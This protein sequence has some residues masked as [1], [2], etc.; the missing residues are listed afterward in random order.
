LGDSQVVS[1]LAFSA[2]GKTLVVLSP[3]RGDWRKGTFSLWDV[4]T[5]KERRRHPFEID[6]HYQG[7]LSPDGQHFAVPT[8]D[9][10]SIR[11][12]DPATGQELRR[13][14]GEAHRPGVV[15]FSADGRVLT[16]SSGDGKARVWDTATGKLRHQFPALRSANIDHVSL[17]RDGALLALAGRD[18]SALHVWDL[19]RGQ[20]RPAFAGHRGSGLT[21]AFTR[22][23]KAV[24]TVS[25]D[26]DASGPVSEWADWSFRLW[27]A[28]SG[29][30]R[31]AT[32]AEPGGGGRLVFVAP[33]ARLLAAV[34]HDGTVRLWD[35]AAGQE[36]RRWKGPTRERTII[37]GTQV[38][39]WA[40]AGIE[41]AGFSPDGKT[42]LAAHGT[43]VSRWDTAT[44]KEL[45]PLQK[46]GSPNFTRC[47]PSPDGRTV[48]LTD[49]GRGGSRLLLLDAASGRLLRVIPARRGVVHLCAFSPDGRT[50]AL[51]DGLAVVLFEAASGQ[52]RGRLAEGAGG[53]SA[54][55][56]SPDGRF[57][58]TAGDRLRLWDL[59]AGRPAG[60]LDGPGFRVTSLAFS[61]DG[62]RLAVG[63]W[64][65]AAL[66]Y[67]VAE[68]HGGER[69]GR[70]KL[71]A[72]VL[73]G[74]WG[75]LA[76]PSGERAYRA[77]QRL[78]AAPEGVP[79][80]RGRLKAPPGPEARRLARLV[81]DLDDDDFAVREQATRELERLGARAEPALRKA[82]E[83]QPS[84]EVRA[85]VGGLLEKLKGGPPL[86]SAELVAQRALEALELA[87]TAEA[88]QALKE[89]TGG[90]PDGAIAEAAKAALERLAARAG[91]A[92]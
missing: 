65:P 88:R 50:L 32:Q 51:A 42:F 28:A 26:P 37:R 47:F 49:Y 41:N 43:A 52:G 57:L 34:T 85:R 19:A 25:Q 89:L 70:G 21:V 61:P 54:L 12:F 48:V 45:R 83:G 9:G 3:G 18:D 14:Q 8:P 27:D 74:L 4:A 38:E 13:T 15:A 80:L 91:E 10:T 5:A 1:A 46:D 77:V 68:L 78:A 92:P 84:A 71:S 64:D 30:E 82:L 59:A 58:A 23:G 7:A 63:G 35:V 55:R 67:D 81:A 73:E 75:E 62:R 60:T 11:L 90:P 31:R 69:P 16:A 87:G 39:K 44:G 29:K 2:D 53:L 76:G 36:L 40:E 79:F 72:A 17:S 24:L 66:V 33:D 20:E 86:P 6:G 56:F 22:D